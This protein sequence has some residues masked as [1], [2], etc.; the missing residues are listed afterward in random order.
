MN[1]ISFSNINCFIF[2]D[3]YTT[4]LYCSLRDDLLTPKANFSL[5]SASSLF[6]T[7]DLNETLQ[8][9]QHQLK[10]PTIKLV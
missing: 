5:I 10:Y 4:F 6:T 1:V 8:G 3:F 2:S 7:K 9:L